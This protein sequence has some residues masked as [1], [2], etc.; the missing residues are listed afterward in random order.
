MNVATNEND[1]I[2]AKRQLC[3]CLL[4]IHSFDLRLCQLADCDSRNALPR[5]ESL[6]VLANQVS[7]VGVE[8]NSI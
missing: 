3:C 7:R 1:L 2:N 5:V 6:K 4:R 8:G